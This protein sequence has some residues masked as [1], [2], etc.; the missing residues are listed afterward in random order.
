[1]LGEHFRLCIDHL[2]KLLF[3]YL[4]NLLVIGLSGTLEQ[5]L[6]GSFLD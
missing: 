1:V 2:G 3:Q 4:G 5:R 6:I